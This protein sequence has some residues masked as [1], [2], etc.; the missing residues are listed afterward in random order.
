MRVTHYSLRYVTW[1]SPWTLQICRISLATCGHQCPVEW[2]DSAPQK[3][4][5]MTH[6]V[7]WGVGPPCSKQVLL[8]SENLGEPGKWPQVESQNNSGR[9]T[10]KGKP[11]R[12]FPED[13]T[14]RKHSSPWNQGWGNI[15]SKTWFALSGNECHGHDPH[16]LDLAA[17][18]LASYSFHPKP[19]PWM[20]RM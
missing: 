2:L 7:Q 6:F 18:S 13:S 5:D 1:K 17:L 9:K 11:L 16:C 10:L 3:H 12:D 14:T 20:T 19:C 8:P 4:N 15:C